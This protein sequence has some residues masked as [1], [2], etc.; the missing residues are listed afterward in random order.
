MSDHPTNF[1]GDIVA[2]ITSAIESKI[3]DSKVEVTGGG[4]HYTIA[5]TSAAFAGLG[6]VDAQRLV[7]SAIAHLMA[8]DGAPVHAVDSLRTIV[9]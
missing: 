4:G 8:G 5:V 3:T 7:Y 1:K 6:R 9:P 2:A